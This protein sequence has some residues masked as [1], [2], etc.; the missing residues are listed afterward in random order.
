MEVTV[1]GESEG[2]D[3]ASTFRICV[4]ERIYVECKVMR[5]LDHSTLLTPTNTLFPIDPI[6]SIGWSNDD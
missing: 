4:E 2:D 6:N 1:D 5:P 3:A